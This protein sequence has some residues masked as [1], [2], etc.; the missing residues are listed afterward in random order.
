MEIW[1]KGEGKENLQVDGINCKHVTQN[2]LPRLEVGRDIPEY[3]WREERDVQN[4]MVYQT[5]PT[6]LQRSD[7]LQDSEKENF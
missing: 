4:T 3:S 2:V 5:S 7:E 1:Q 6:E